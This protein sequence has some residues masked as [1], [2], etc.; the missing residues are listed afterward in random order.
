MVGRFGADGRSGPWRTSY[1]GSCVCK[2][3]SLECLLTQR[4]PTQHKEHA[5]MS[6]TEALTIPT[7]TVDGVEVPAAGH[8]RP[9][10]LAH[11][12]GLQRPP[13]D[14]LQDQGPLRRLRR[15]GRRSPRTRSTRP[16]RS[17]S[18]AASIDT[19][20]DDR[21]GHLR[22]ADFFDVEPHPDDHLPLHQV[23]A[24]RQGPLDRRR[25]P[26]GPRHHPPVPLAVT[27]E[28]GAVRPVGRR[29]HRLRRPTPSSTGRPS[30]SPGTRPSRPAACSS[31]RP[32]RSTSRPKPSASRPDDP[33]A[34]RWSPG[35]WIGGGEIHLQFTGCSSSGPQGR[36]RRLRNRAW[37]RG[38]IDRNG[39][40]RFTSVVGWTTPW[41]TS[42]RGHA[43]RGAFGSEAS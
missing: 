19:R 33:C 31:A 23:T 30:A 24:G 15:H 7:R 43:A 36:L 26:H 38:V 39:G 41:G 11:R 35:L 40:S 8:L 3:R 34:H 42:S 16:S 21:D 4:L 37:G 18:S 28:G 32:S 2:D 6:T 25:R 29:P 27:F 5:A 13:P 9:R 14:G 1:N 10:R 12:G 17:R 22:S 20:D